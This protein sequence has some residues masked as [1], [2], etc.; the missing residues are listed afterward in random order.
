MMIFAAS[1]CWRP[2]LGFGNDTVILRQSCA[3]DGIDPVI[4][5]DASACFQWLVGHLLSGTCACPVDMSDGAVHSLVCAEVVSH[6]HPPE[7]I[8]S[9]MLGSVL[10]ISFYSA[11]ALLGEKVHVITLLLDDG[12]G[13]WPY[14]FAA[15]IRISPP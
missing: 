4:S 8:V 3:L 10:S 15:V 14:I 5:N 1:Q 7:L 9:Y 12:D 13:L 11:D 2:V 6:L